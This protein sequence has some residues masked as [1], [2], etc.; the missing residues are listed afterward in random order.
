MRRE[1]SISAIKHII[2]VC[3]L[4]CYNSRMESEPDTT[5]IVYMDEYPELAKR[6]WLR[7][8]AQARLASTAVEQTTI[9]Y[10]PE[11]PDG[12]A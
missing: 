2:K 8:L 10:L 11:P 12:A 3:F 6:V 7:R 1:N 5:N 4:L 9:L